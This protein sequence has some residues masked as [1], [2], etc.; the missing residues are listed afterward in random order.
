MSFPTKR[1]VVRLLFLTPRLSVEIF[2]N[3]TLFSKFEDLTIRVFGACFES[4]EPYWSL[5]RGIEGLPCLLAGW[6][7]ATQ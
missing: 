6:S 5:G 4:R 7:L 1:P 2:A 3:W